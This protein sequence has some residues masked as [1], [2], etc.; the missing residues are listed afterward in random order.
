M[1][2]VDVFTKVALVFGWTT[3]VDEPEIVT[4]VVG[5]KRTFTFI[6]L[7]F[8]MPNVSILVADIE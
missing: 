7:V 5:V 3:G 6:D 4:L 8:D 1:F 2:E